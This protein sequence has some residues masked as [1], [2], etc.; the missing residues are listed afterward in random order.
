MEKYATVKLSSMPS[1]QKA[2]PKLDRSIRS[3]AGRS[4]AL[5]I[6]IINGVT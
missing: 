4:F 5:S 3:P 6:A 1:S 2:A